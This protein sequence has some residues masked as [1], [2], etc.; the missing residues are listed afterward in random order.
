MHAVV[1]KTAEPE[2]VGFDIVPALAPKFCVVNVNSGA[3]LAAV[4][5]LPGVL[6]PELPEHIRIADA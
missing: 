4:A 5:G 2:K 3:E 6:E 1:A